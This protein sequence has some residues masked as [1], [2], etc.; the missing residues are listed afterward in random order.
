MRSTY[1]LAFRVDGL[2]NVAG[3]ERVHVDYHSFA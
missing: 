1:S 2:P 3:P